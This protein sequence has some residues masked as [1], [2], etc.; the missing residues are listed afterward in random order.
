MKS[1]RARSVVGETSAGL[2]VSAFFQLED[3]A[4]GVELWRNVNREI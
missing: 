3:I 4:A 1:D 2:G